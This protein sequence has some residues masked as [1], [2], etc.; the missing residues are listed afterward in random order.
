M[1][2]EEGK[3]SVKLL[4]DTLVAGEQHEAGDKVDVYE[5]EKDHLVASGA[6]EEAKSSGKSSSKG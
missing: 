6:A 3:V 1:A 2:S 4:Q 5:A